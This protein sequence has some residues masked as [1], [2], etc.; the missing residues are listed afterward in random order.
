MRQHVS[1]DRF[2]RPAVVYDDVFVA[3]CND[4]LRNMT[5]RT[6]ITVRVDLRANAQRLVLTAIKGERT[7]QF[8]AR[9]RKPDR[10]YRLRRL[11]QLLDEIIA[12]F[13]RE[14]I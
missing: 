3:A 8:H 6:D 1:A 5:G 12:Y 2:H 4:Y 10:E 9:M 11:A 14:A 13:E 7:K